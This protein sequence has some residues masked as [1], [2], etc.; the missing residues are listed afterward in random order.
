MGLA[1]AR[2]ISDKVVFLLP[3][4][5]VILPLMDG[6]RTLD[7][8]VAEVGRGLTRPAL[9]HIVAQLDD[10]CLIEGPRFEALHA[11]ARAD[12][13]SHPTLPPAASGQFADIVASQA[14][15]QNATPEQKAEAGPGKV[16][17]LFDGWMNQ[18]LQGAQNIP[19]AL[20]KAIIVPHIDYGRGWPNYASVYGRLRGLPRPDR[21]VILGTNHFG[22]STGVAG[23]DKGYESPLGVCPVDETLVKSLRS[24]LGDKLFENRFDHENEHSIELQIMWV[25]HVFGK[26]ASG[27]YPKVFGALVHD[28]TVNNGES[29]DGNGIG[30]QAFV[31]ALKGSLAGLPGTTLVVSSADL[32]H[33]G[34]GFGDQVQLAG[35]EDAAKAARDKVLEHDREM[36]GLIA[37]N[38]PHELVSSM[39][40]QQNP[41]RWCSIGNI[42]ATLLT[43]DPTKVDVLNYVAAMDQQGMTLVSSAAALVH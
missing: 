29:Y 42:V 15:G 33:V 22:T 16:K 21:V 19:T 40:W 10:A 36:I 26:D 24:K 43:V 20:P 38:K 31:D 9:D 14:L 32:S 7:T 12:F 8:I 25:Q 41:T 30:L 34:P 23:C 39:A 35:E 18:A 37:A 11:K 2:Q 4:V 27:T 6:T 17:E 5:Q 1:D 3:A 13:D 28:P